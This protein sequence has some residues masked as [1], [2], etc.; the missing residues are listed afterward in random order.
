M[1]F[2]LKKTTTTNTSTSEFSGMVILI[3]GT[4]KGLGLSI[5]EYFVER[6]ASVIGVARNNSGLRALDGKNPAADLLVLEGDISNEKD[7]T[8]IQKSI[9]KKYSKIDVLVN[10]AG[11]NIHKP[12][13]KLTSVDFEIMVQTNIKGVFL[14]SQMVLPSMKKRKS[15]FIINVGSKISHNTNVKPNNVIYAT[16]KYAIEGFSFAL[17]K[18]L[19]KFGVRVSCLMPGTLNTFF[20]LKSKEFLSTG[21]VAEFIGYMI[22]HKEVDFESVVIKSIKQD[23]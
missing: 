16:T 18:E 4:G 7:V 11:V 9:L 2:L 17:N 8:N 19:K 20:S 6:G 15:G 13:E 22:K 1:S 3:T 10:N 5:A 23:I 14:M 12:L 21:H